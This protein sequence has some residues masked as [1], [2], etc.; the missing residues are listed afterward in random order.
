MGVG[1]VDKF[2]EKTGYTTPGAPVFVAAPGGDDECKYSPVAEFHH[3]FEPHKGSFL[4]LFL[5]FPVIS[6]QMVA[7]YG[8]G[9]T[10]AG[11]GT[12]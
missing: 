5:F 4:I 11:S 6:N 12:R 10:D 8:G 9:C 3:E 2:G 7:S 1:A